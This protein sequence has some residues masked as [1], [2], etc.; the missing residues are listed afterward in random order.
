MKAS[1]YGVEETDAPF[2][3]EELEIEDPTEGEVLVRVVGTGICHTDLIARSGDMPL[4]L[5]GVMGHEGSGVVEKVGPGVEDVAVG[6]RVIMGWP[7]CGKCR[8]CRQGQHRYCAELGSAVLSGRR[9][10]GP[11]S[12]Q[13]G[14]SR[15]DGGEVS[16]RFFG[17]S[18]FATY[19]LTTANSVV[20][21]DDDV[22]LT[23]AGVL[24]CGITTGAGAI[25]NS[26]QPKPGETL[27]IFGVGAV[28]LSAVMAARNTP[29]ATIIAVD[30]HD[31]RLE[32]AARYGAT[33]TI[34]SKDE[35]AK[36]R[37]RQIVGGEVDHAVDC[38]G[39]IAVIEDA[40]EVVG[41]LGQ[42]ILVGGAPAGATF[43][44]DHMSTLWGRRVVGTLGG[45]G[46]AHD[47]I[48]AL[49]QLNKQGR[50]P[51]DELVRVYEFDQIDQAIADSA[52]GETIKP[53]LRVG[54]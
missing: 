43:S 34:N 19:A 36:A 11:K 7:Y 3:L 38:T 9:F 49:L 13:S 51:F 45:G 40:A 23:S 15:P 33:H 39:V 24:A 52:S 50:F 20:R 47:L 25:L 4:P 17:Q 28:G 1:A 18:S 42:L 31:S 54:E 12:G 8:N 2:T 22:D 5:P 32:L 30:V 14:Y 16:G 10:S 46:T 21:I 48:P 26:A 41:M 29:A 37:I 27:V 6:D 35:S 53:V 44:L